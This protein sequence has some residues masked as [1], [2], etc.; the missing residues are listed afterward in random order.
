MQE[1]LGQGRKAKTEGKA[2]AIAQKV[3]KGYDEGDVGQ[4]TDIS[5]AGLRAMSVFAGLALLIFAFGA[6]FREMM[7]LVA[8]ILNCNRR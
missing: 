2:E 1:R 6:F 8:L 4:G 3:D 5:V 7:Y